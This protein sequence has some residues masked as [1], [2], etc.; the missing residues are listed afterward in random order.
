MAYSAL[1][2][3]DLSGQK[4]IEDVIGATCTAYES[5]HLSPAYKMTY[6]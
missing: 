6:I 2:T 1:D 5:T 3:Y 4:L